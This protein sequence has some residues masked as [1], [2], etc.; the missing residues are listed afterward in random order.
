VSLG[1]VPEDLN[2]VGERK[3][4]IVAKGLPLRAI[5]VQLA[6]ALQEAHWDVA[7]Q[8]GRPAYRLHRDA[9]VEDTM[10]WLIQRDEDRRADR[11]RRQRLAR[12]E[13]AR[14]TLEM[15]PEE[16]AELAKTDPLLAR[17]VQD[18]HSRDL[19]E[20]LLTLPPEQAAQLRETGKVYIPYLEASERLQQAVLRIGNM[21]RPEVAGDSPPADDTPEEV[22]HWQAH[23]PHDL[24][25]FEDCRVEHGFGVRLTLAIPTARGLLLENYVNHSI[26]D[27]A[28]FPRYPS[29]DD[30]SSRFSRLLMATGVP[31]KETAFEM[32]MQRDKEGFRAEAAVREERHEREWREPTDP[33]L[34]QTVVVGDR[35]FDGFA[36]FQAFIAAETGLSAVSDYFTL[37]G[38]FI[39]DEHREGIPL[40]RL[41][42]LVGEHYYYGEDVYLWRKAGSCLVFL[43][44]D[45]PALARVETPESI[46]ADYRARLEEQGGLTLD[47]VAEL[48]LTLEGRGLPGH[49]LCCSMAR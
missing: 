41:L 36:E 22:R 38:P 17:S 15:S 19:L 24:V 46:I 9:G 48:A 13:L 29:L 28:L 47:D 25:K 5:M 33:D 35:Q 20:I 32:A 6:E 45:W 14:R 34:L 10:D 21:W 1:V 7:N 31:D 49:G 26:S 12:I 27:V 16:L 30:G 11:K 8:D 37:R 39:R 40:W 18:P 23:L 2:T 44:A 4:T 43:R 3:F 42:C